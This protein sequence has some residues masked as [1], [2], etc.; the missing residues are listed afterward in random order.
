LISALTR[1]LLP[2]P[3]GAEIIYNVPGATV[4]L[5]VAGIVEVEACEVDA[6]INY[7]PCRMGSDVRPRIIGRFRHW[8][9]RGVSH[10]GLT[11]AGCLPV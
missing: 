8:G 10:P 5:P 1:L 3:D 4:R 6:F 2:A 11:V 7:M 9:E